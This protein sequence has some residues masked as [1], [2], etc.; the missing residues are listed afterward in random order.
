MID[1]IITEFFL[2]CFKAAKS[3]ENCNR[4]ESGFDCKPLFIL[5]FLTRVTPAS[6]KIYLQTVSHEALS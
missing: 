3:F 6:G 5:S 1:V 2:L 4:L